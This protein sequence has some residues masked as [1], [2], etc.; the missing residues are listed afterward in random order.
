MKTLIHQIITP[1]QRQSLYTKFFVSYCRYNSQN[2]AHFQLLLI[3][4][5][6]Q[7][8]FNGQFQLAENQF[9]NIYIKSNMPMKKQVAKDMYV[10]Q[11]HSI[12]SRYSRSILSKVKQQSERIPHQDILILLN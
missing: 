9:M 11:L 3:N 12:Y 5:P 10:G 8:W 6:L 4:K 1:E 7:R 2:E